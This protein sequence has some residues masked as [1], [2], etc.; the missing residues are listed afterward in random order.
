MLTL[1]DHIEAPPPQERPSVAHPDQGDRNGTPLAAPDP[2][3]M[4]RAPLAPLLVHAAPAGH[5]THTDKPPLVADRMFLVNANTPTDDQYPGS[6][7][8]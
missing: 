4:V 1:S 2:L 5:S 8:I 6:G 3:A 7:A